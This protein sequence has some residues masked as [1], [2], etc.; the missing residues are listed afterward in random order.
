MEVIPKAVSCLWNVFPWLDCLVRP[1]WER[2]GLAWQRLAMQGWR[3]SKPG[4]Y[5]FIGEVEKDGEGLSKRELGEGSNLDV[6]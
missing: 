3:T 6:K 4:L 2:K 5:L 1:Q